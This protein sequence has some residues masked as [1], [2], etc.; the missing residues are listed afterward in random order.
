MKVNFLLFLMVLLA[1]LGPDA[2]ASVDLDQ[3]AQMDTFTSSEYS[4]GA[5]FK[6]EVLSPAKMQISP[7]RTEGTFCSPQGACSKELQFLKAGHEPLSANDF[8][9]VS[10]KDLIATP[11]YMPKGEWYVGYVPFWSRH[12]VALE[13][14]KKPLAIELSTPLFGLSPG[15]AYLSWNRYW[16]N[17]KPVDPDTYCKYYD[18]KIDRTIIPTTLSLQIRAKA[19]V[20]PLNLPER[21]KISTENPKSEATANFELVKIGTKSFKGRPKEVGRG[22]TYYKKTDSYDCPVGRSFHVTVYQ[23][24]LM[25]YYI[26]MLTTEY[27][28]DSM[29]LKTEDGGLMTSKTAFGGYLNIDMETGHGRVQECKD[30]FYTR[31]YCLKDETELRPDW[32]DINEAQS[33]LLQ[34]R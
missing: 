33:T 25:E 9:S 26:P 31:E 29:E 7:R 22:K 11:A 1:N 20:D 19:V 34:C 32:I 16:G 12:T 4:Y 13:D 5:L 15:Y 18:C 23:T 3:L 14:Q 30:S 2:K 17:N 27:R 8:M 10:I 21:F 6:V 24:L 28:Y